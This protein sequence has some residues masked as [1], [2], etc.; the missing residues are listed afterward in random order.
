MNWYFASWPIPMPWQANSCGKEQLLLSRKITAKTIFPILNILVM[1]LTFLME[2]AGNGGT[3]KTKEPGTILKLAKHYI[4]IW[5]IQHQK[6][7]FG[8]TFLIRMVLSV[9][10]CLMVRLSSNNN[11]E[12]MRQENM[13]GENDWRLRG[14]DSYLQNCKFKLSAFKSMPGKSMHAHCEFC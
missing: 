1:T 13:A 14:Q 5:I 2:I 9:E 10:F 4:L 6:A 8:I 3:Q 11:A 7:P 12:R